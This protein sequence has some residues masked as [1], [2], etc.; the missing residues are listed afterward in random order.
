MRKVLLPNNCITLMYV[1]SS[2]SPLSHLNSEELHAHEQRS[3]VVCSV[4]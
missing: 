1:G 2:T 4:R 3:D